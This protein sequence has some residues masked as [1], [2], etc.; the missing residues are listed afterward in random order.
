MRVSKK[1][2]RSSPALPEIARA[3]IAPLWTTREISNA[4]GA[5]RK[6]RK[7]ITGTRAFWTAVP[8]DRPTQTNNDQETFLA[9]S[10]TRDFSP[11]KLPNPALSRSRV[12]SIAIPSRI[13]SQATRRS[14]APRFEDAA[15]EAFWGGTSLRVSSSILPVTY[16]THWRILGHAFPVPPRSYRRR[17]GVLL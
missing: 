13:A 2:E 14:V 9:K 6:P 8:T 15:A 4:A 10:A 3:W 17:A 5:A 1:G 12:P 11:K 16:R 7:P